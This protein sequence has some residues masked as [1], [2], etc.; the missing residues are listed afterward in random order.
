MRARRC[1]ECHVGAP[2]LA[3]TGEERRWLIAGIVSIG[4]GILIFVMPR[5]LNY[6]VAAY[7]VSVG[8]L[9][10][11]EATD[12]P[13]SLVRDPPRPRNAPVPDEDRAR[14]PILGHGASR[15]S[16]TAEI[17]TAGGAGAGRLDGCDT[18]CFATRSASLLV[19]AIS[20]EAKE[21]RKSI[22]TK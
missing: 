7:F 5:L 2:L 8:I 20:I 15:S 11:L 21:W 13:G 14:T 9:L 22:P 1:D 19:P 12:W 16:A 6:V 3:Y 18:M 17:A 10:V 4:V